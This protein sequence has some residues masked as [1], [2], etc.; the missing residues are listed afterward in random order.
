MGKASEGVS[1]KACVYECVCVKPVNAST[2]LT[3]A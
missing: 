2:A 3:A 1:E